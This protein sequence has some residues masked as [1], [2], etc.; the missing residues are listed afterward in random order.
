MLKAKNARR[1]SDIV[2]L[3]FLYRKLDAIPMRIET[4]Y[5]E[6]RKRHIIALKISDIIR[7]NGKE[8]IF[9]VRK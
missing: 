8:I 5:E 4:T 3:C 6:R 9:E 1:D 2:K 7:R